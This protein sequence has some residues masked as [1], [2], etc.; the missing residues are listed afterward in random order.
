MSLHKIPLTQLE[1]V[2]LTKHGLATKVPSQL[3]DVFR[4]GMEWAKNNQKESINPGIIAELQGELNLLK[5]TSKKRV[6]EIYHR[7]RASISD[8]VDSNDHLKAAITKTNDSVC[9]TLGKVL[10]YPWYK[11][12]L[13][14][15][16]YATGDKGVCVGDHVAESIAMEAAKELDELK[17]KLNLLKSDNSFESLFACNK[18]QVEMIEALQDDLNLLKGDL[19]SNHRASIADLVNSNYDLK[20]ALRLIASEKYLYKKNETRRRGSEPS[21][22]AEVNARCEI[23]KKAIGSVEYG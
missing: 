10:G 20:T 16:P 15:F 22:E 17:L 9:Q 21:W 12:D 13:K 14:T 11:D 8:L 19:I 18:K 1:E 23:A 5:G 3:S 2:G 6:L 4:L 7:Q